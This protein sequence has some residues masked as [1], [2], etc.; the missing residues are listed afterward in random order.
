[1]FY[2]EH[3]SEIIFLLTSLFFDD[4]IIYAGTLCVLV[5]LTIFIVLA[6]KINC[7]VM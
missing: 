2:Y 1:M 3:F 5:I 4:F 7:N 6:N